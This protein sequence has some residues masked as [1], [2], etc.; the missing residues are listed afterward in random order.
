M[1]GAGVTRSVMF[2]ENKLKYFYDVW[3][4]VSLWCCILLW[5]FTLKYASS[6]TNWKILQH[7]LD[8]S[9]TSFYDCF[10]SL[11]SELCWW[12]KYL[13]KTIFRRVSSWWRHSHLWWMQERLQTSGTDSLHTTQSSQLVQE[14]KS[15]QKSWF[16]VQWGR[17]RKYLKKTSNIIFIRS[18]VKSSSPKDGNYVSLGS[19]SISGSGRKYF[20]EVVH[21]YF[22]SIPG[23]TE[24]DTQS[25]ETG[26]SSAQVK[27]ESS[28]SDNVKKY[29]FSDAQTNT[30]SSSGKSYSYCRGKWG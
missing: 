30:V 24:C 3:F 7:W 11:P 21:K 19:P 9:K 1:L 18:Q 6:W 16:R 23:Q 22:S 8:T 13:I 27:T 26:A 5:T 28:N 20:S 15:V 29:L 17:F 4:G 12:Q 25:S 2:D 10:V 14:I